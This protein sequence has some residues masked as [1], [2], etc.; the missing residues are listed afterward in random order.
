VNYLNYFQILYFKIDSKYYHIICN[1]MSCPICVSSFNKSSHVMITCPDV[2]CAYVACKECVRTYILGSTADPHCMN[3]RKTYEQ[4]F[5]TANLNVSWITK[6]YKKHKKSLLV[7][8]E[9]SKLPETMVKVHQYQQVKSLEKIEGEL[10]KRMTELNN[11]AAKVKSELR[12][13][14]RNIHLTR[15]GQYSEIDKKQ[16]IMPCSDDN[17]RGFLSSAYKCEACKLYTCS[18]CH[19]ITGFAKI[20]DEHVCNEDNVKSAALIKKETKP[21]PSCGVR[22]QKI[23]G[24][25][26][27]WCP[28]CKNAF[29]WRT[30]Q[31]DTGVIH[32]PHFYT[33]QQE[34]GKGAASR[35]PGDVVC[36]GLDDY[37]IVRRAVIRH[38]SHFEMDFQNLIHAKLL[39]MSNLYRMLHTLQGYTI[40]IL[41]EAVRDASNNENE[42]VQYILKEITTEELGNIIVRK[43]NL[44]KKNV[45]LLHVWELMLTI[46]IENHNEFTYNVFR[47]PS[48]SQNHYMCIFDKR[49]N[50]LIDALQNIIKYCNNRFAMISATFNCKTPFIDNDFK[51][52]NQ[53][54]SQSILKSTKC[55]SYPNAEEQFDCA[56]QT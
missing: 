17:C 49:F 7:E 38:I 36:G 28:G 16:F 40:N 37:W 20:N 46:G 1:T 26:Q 51:V 10:K 4:E 52:V 24:C 9:I 22:I 43:D 33:W 45:E 31:V 48:D 50:T 53:K 12:N 25:D 3:C 35:N 11:E 15:N 27:M 42:R 21:C 29:S 32:N 54:S 19:E 44:L 39:I 18:K 2:Q 34:N 6:I 14:L 56:T 47:I 23:S 30:G 55:K 5:Q 13:T 8:R 41:R